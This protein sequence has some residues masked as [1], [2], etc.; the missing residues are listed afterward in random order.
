M[1]RFKFWLFL[2]PLGFLLTGCSAGPE[3]T[4]EDFLAAI[5]SGEISEAK[6]LATESTGELLELAAGF[7]ALDVDPDF[8]FVLVEKVVDGNRATITYTNGPD[9]KIETVDLVKL[10]GKWKV[11]EQKD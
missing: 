7:G 9:G 10:D 4:A 3:D 11:H 5:A 1:N 6:E 8:E 2:V